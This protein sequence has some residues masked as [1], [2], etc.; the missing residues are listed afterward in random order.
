MD[1]VALSPAFCGFDVDAGAPPHEDA[2]GLI[3]VERISDIRRLVDEG[4]AE[5]RRDVDA[6]TR[7]LTRLRLVLPPAMLDRFASLDPMSVEYE[8]LQME[9]YEAV[10]GDEYSPNNE[11]HEYDGISPGPPLEPAPFY[12]SPRDAGYWTVVFGHIIQMLDAPKGAR[13]LEVGFGGGGLTE[14]MVRTGLNV[15]GVEIRESN[16]AYLRRRLDPLGLGFTSLTGDISTIA[17]EGPFDRIIFFESFHHV[18][19]F[20]GTLSR[21]LSH[22]APDG[23]VIF[24]AEPF[25]EDHDPI[26]PY[27]WGVR[28][29]GGA[30]SAARE[31]GWLEI[32]FRKSFFLEMLGRLGLTGT[33]HRLPGYHHAHVLVAR[34]RD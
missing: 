33:E 31:V 34:R 12:M 27:P 25:V 22:L 4:L 10:A 11:G 30:L 13:V 15:T 1:V 2:H 5:R 32:G 7:D 16:G 26:L 8:R 29:D 23:A 18:P 28:L 19:D 20:H 24:A 17:L 9:V 21:L 6:G 14:L 3:F